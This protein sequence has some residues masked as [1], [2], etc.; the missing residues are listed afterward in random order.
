MSLS[1]YTLLYAIALKME[2]FNPNPAPTH[3]RRRIAQVVTSTTESSVSN[4]V[5][6]VSK[7]T[8]PPV[9][10]RTNHN[11][12]SNMSPP[13]M[14]PPTI[15]P[16]PPPSSSFVAPPLP[17]ASLQGPSQADF[18]ALKA[19]LV[20]ANATIKAHSDKIVSLADANTAYCNEVTTRNAELAAANAIISIKDKEIALQKVINAGL[21]EQ[22]AGL[23]EEVADLRIEAEFGTGNSLAEE[24]RIAIEN[25]L[26]HAM[27]ILN[28]VNFPYAQD[29]SL[30]ADDAIRSTNS[31]ETIGHK[32][33]K[34]N[35]QEDLKVNPN[36]S[37]LVRESNSSLSLPQEKNTAVVL[38]APVNSSILQRRGA[39]K[40][41]NK[42][43][44]ENIVDGSSTLAF[45]AKAKPYVPKFTLFVRG[46]TDAVTND[47][48]RD[49]V[50]TK[51][52]TE[53]T[54]SERKTND[55]G[56]QAFLEFSTEYDS[57]YALKVL[58]D[59]VIPNGNNTITFGREKKK[60][61]L[62]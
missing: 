3:V 39:Q 21:V 38:E 31:Q 32:Q 24:K 53:F 11:S 57:N 46:L 4:V 6:T 41:G 56:T 34:K 12:L 62:K 2:G 5:N 27:H 26:Y 23:E 30:E 58:G 54:L 37:S 43:V 25:A 28:P 61:L 22:I 16:P 45:V 55:R 13:A 35:P 9:A 52:K 50:K 7:P 1:V 60:V 15:P 48:I 17:S 18:N 47:Q 10:L 14:L 40:G 33:G 8:P 19:E 42:V 20:A 44:Q 59:L 36:K 29:N 51:V 49:L